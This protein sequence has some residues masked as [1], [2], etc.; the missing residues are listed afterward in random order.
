MPDGRIANNH[1]HDTK[2]S[3]EKHMK[4][5]KAYWPEMKDE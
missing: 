5:L 2:E 1:I 4:S 3:A